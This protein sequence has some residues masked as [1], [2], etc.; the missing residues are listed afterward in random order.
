MRAI[1]K[2]SPHNRPGL[3]LISISIFDHAR[4]EDYDSESES[5]EDHGGGDDM[6]EELEQVHRLTSYRWRWLRSCPS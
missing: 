2:A 5:R 6:G 3:D 1:E 4:G